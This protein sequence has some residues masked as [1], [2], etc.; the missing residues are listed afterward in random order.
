MTCHLHNLFM[1]DLYTKYKTDRKTETESEKEES[2]TC[3]QDTMKHTLYR[4]QVNNIITC[5]LDRQS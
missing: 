4:E 5:K 3:N 1:T 2:S